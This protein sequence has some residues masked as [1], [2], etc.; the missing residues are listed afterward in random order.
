[1]K[2]KLTLHV[3]YS[4]GDACDPVIRTVLQSLVETAADRGML[5]QDFNLVV[6]QHDFD[7]ETKFDEQ[8]SVEND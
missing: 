8:P 2:A 7:I 4:G 6:E 1:M 5:T 3:T